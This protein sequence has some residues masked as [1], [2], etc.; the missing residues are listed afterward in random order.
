MP[1]LGHWG[2]GHGLV[3]AAKG[4]WV[5]LGAWGCGCEP[6]R[7]HGTV[8]GMPVCQSGC[9]RTRLSIPPGCRAMALPA[10]NQ[11]PG[12]AMHPNPTQTTPSQLHVSRQQPEPSRP[13]GRGHNTERSHDAARGR[14]TSTSGEHPAP[15]PH[16][17]PA[18]HELTTSPMLRAAR[19]TAR[20]GV[21]VTT[22]GGTATASTGA[23]R[24]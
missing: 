2:T 16:G 23:K 4:V 10:S 21:G 3:G 24:R 1:A 17:H 5:V 19:P 15:G 8:L 18:H 9:R 7:S 20:A 12:A 22:R 11:A 13:P 6:G 14:R